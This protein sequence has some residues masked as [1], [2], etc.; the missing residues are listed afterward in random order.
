[1]LQLL[2]SNPN[3]PSPKEQEQTLLL[4]LRTAKNAKQAAVALLNTIYSRQQAD[5]LAL[6]SAA[7]DLVPMRRRVMNNFSLLAANRM[8]HLKVVVVALVFA[9]LVAGIGF[10][11]RVI[12]GSGIITVIKAGKPVTA[13]TAE[14]R[15]IR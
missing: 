4:E 5:N 10:T 14:T 12:D 8:T 9:T 1:V 3:G 2:L 7:S 13:S 15:T 6:Q 11:A